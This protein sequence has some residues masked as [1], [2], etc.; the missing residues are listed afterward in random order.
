MTPPITIKCYKCAKMKTLAEFSRG[1]S[2]ASR[3][4]RQAWCKQC[5]CDYCTERRRAN[6]AK[7]RNAVI[8]RICGSEAL[9]A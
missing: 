6:G 1:G 9:N 2:M 3:W 4:D 8:V 7:P 5:T